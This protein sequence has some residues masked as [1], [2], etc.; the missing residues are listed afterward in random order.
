MTPWIAAL[1]ALLAAAALWYRWRYRVITV[2]G[3]SMEPTY[4]DGDRL[5]VRRSRT[6]GRG[7]AVVFAPPGPGLPGD[8]PW[9]VKRATATAGDR[10]PEEMTGAVRVPVVPAGYLAVLGDNPRSLDSRRFGLV[11]ESALLGVVVRRLGDERGTPHAAI[12]A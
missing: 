8:P 10:V 7:A 6:A 12:A 11:P 9:L 2:S 5:L 4:V 3:E 1:V